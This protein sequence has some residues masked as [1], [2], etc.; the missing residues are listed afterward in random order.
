[1]SGFRAKPLPS[2]SRK[3]CPRCTHPLRRVLVVERDPLLRWSVQSYLARWF[4]VTTTASARDAER[5]LRVN[6]VD[7]VV[8]ADGIARSSV[9]HLE[10]I[11]AQQNPSVLLVRT[12]IEAGD[13]AERNSQ[14]HARDVGPIE[15]RIE[16]PFELSS[17]ARLLGVS[18]RELAN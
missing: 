14:P 16:K 11:A 8:I 13:D 10:E 3:C 18:E 4:D 7:A 1:M 2:L 15:H 17:L 9:Q 12:V 6:Q 5:W